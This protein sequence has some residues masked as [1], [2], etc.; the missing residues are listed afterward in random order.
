MKKTYIFVFSFFLLT[1]TSQAFAL[2]SLQFLEKCRKAHVHKKTDTPQKIVTKAL[3]MGSCSG[4]VGGVVN[5]VNLVG[6]MLGRQGAIKKNFICLPE[7]IKATDLLIEALG[8]IEKNKQHHN[9][10][11]HLSIYAFMTGKYPCDEFSGEK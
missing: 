1:I 7:N 10:A 4:M 3:D 6:N 11:A 9:L 2:S 5:G 8:Y